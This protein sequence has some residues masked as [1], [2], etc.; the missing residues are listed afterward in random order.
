MAWQDTT[1][2]IAVLAL[3]Y[4]LIPQ[5]VKA[6]KEKKPLVSIQTALITTIGMATISLT[7]LTLDLIFASIMN[8][9]AAILW[10]ATLTQSIIYKE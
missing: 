7:Y 4:A 10:A 1:L 9:T 3:N 5:V 2:T 6:H 8:F